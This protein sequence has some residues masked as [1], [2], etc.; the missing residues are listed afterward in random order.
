MTKASIHAL[1]SR[2]FFHLGIRVATIALTI[3]IKK[4]ITAACHRRNCDRRRAASRGC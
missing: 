2:F 4:K 1:S 3:A